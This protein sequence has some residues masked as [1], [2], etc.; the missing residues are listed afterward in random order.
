MDLFT[1]IA[2][3]FYD[4]QMLHAAL[5]HLPFCLAIAGVPLLLWN[6]FRRPKSLTLDYI[7]LVLYLSATGLAYW[8]SQVGERA[9]AELPNTLPTEVWDQINLHTNIAGRVWTISGV[10]AVV[11]MLALFEQRDRIRNIVR[12][13]A[14]LMGVGMML[15][16]LRA[17]HE[18]GKLVYVYGIGTPA[19]EIQ[20][21]RGKAAASNSTATR[22][23]VADAGASEA[24]SLSAPLTF[25]ADVQPVFTAHCVSC[26]NAS[27][28][29]SGLDLSSL[30]GLLEG[31][32]KA[33][34]ALVLDAP[35]T[36][37]LFRYLDGQLQPRMPKDEPPLTA[38]QIAVLGRWARDYAAKEIGAAHAQASAA[39]EPLQ[40][41]NTTRTNAR[42]AWTPDRFKVLKGLDSLSLTADLRTKIRYDHLATVYEA[43]PAQSESVAPDLDFALDTQERI[44]RYQRYRRLSLAEPPPNVPASKPELKNP[45]D[46]FIYDTFQKNNIP[47]PKLA[48][49]RD[50]MRRAYLDL[51]GVYPDFEDVKHFVDDA[52]EKKYEQLV[53][54]L[55]ARSTD[56]ADN[57]VPQW[58]DALAS[59][60]DMAFPRERDGTRSD[61]RNW[62]AESFKQNRPLDEMVLELFK[63]DAF[64]PTGRY[65]LSQSRETSLLSAADVAQ[66][67]LGEPMRCASCHNHFQDRNLTLDRTISFASYFS[68]SD[69]ELIR[70]GKLSGRFLAPKL[71]FSLPEYTEGAPRSLKNRKEIAGLWLIDPTND[72]FAQVMANRIWKRYFGVGLYEPA[73]EWCSDVQASN[74]ELLRWL[75]DDFRSGGF[76]VKRTVRL[77]LTSRTY[78]HVFDSNNPTAFDRT[79][80]N[81][82]R[83]FASPALRRL[84]AEQYWD[85]A[86]KVVGLRWQG[87]ERTFRMELPPALVVAMGGPI[88][89]REAQTDRIDNASTK[90][91]LLMMNGETFNDLIGDS[92]AISKITGNFKEQGDLGSALRAVYRLVLSREP[93]DDEQKIAEHYFSGVVQSAEPREQSSLKDAFVKDTCWSLLTSPEFLFVP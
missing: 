15:W 16:T 56:Y 18:G 82:P 83:Y 58:A 13:G 52:N 72:R 29:K 69:L 45:I 9:M 33:G 89:R 11:L 53:D 55:L 10:T 91:A 49:D 59:D 12:A 75:A 47:A 27:D 14:L 36:S 88:A 35:E 57:W 80:P 79:A 40:K 46:S 77:I 64:A 41:S 71:P 87:T 7:L 78:R 60:H 6:I 22:P 5:A 1:D 28:A 73:D 68:E 4:P 65:I 50:F 37:P 54:L 61:F 8:A 23:I 85:S 84:T 90:Q 93:N 48:T 62:L 74:P 43:P 30:G 17:G 92:P 26:H 39:G 3:S 31:G 19:L 34:P 70:C 20:T 51:L 2:N 21:H 32:K 42:N 81:V 63:A 66:V 25:A 24:I 76:D 67:F 86:R 44:S 38:D